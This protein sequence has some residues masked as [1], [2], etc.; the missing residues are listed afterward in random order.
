MSVP[1]EGD[2]RARTAETVIHCGAAPARWIAAL[3]MCLTLWLLPPSVDNRRRVDHAPPMLLALT[4]IDRWIAR[5]L[6]GETLKDIYPRG[7]RRL[8]EYGLLRGNCIR[9]TKHGF[10]MHVDRLDAIKWAIHYFGE[11][12][13]H[14]S[15]AYKALLSPGGVAI[16][17]GA[18][19]G[20][21]ALLA[22][23]LVQRHGRVLAFEPASKVY[24]QLLSNIALNGFTQ[25]EPHKCAVADFRGEA[26]LH[27]MGDNE[28]AQAS[29]FARD[30]ADLCETVPV[31]PFSDV[32]AM[33]HPSSVDLIKIDI[34]GAEGM[35][36]DQLADERNLNPR[37]AV[38]VEMTNADAT[39]ALERLLCAGFHARV[40][41]N[42][43]NTA[44]YRKPGRAPLAEFSGLTGFA[45]LVLS[46]D[47]RVFDAIN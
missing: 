38:F 16:D 29:M 22:A 2:F 21:H 4:D 34:E 6:P 44:F 47:E 18:N 41:R 37:C 27:M 32:L 46:R 25:I 20:Y 14:I 36:L 5:N 19:I 9:E 43:Y 17:L 23:Q 12:E 11:W 24:H 45:D 3:A 30:G 10:R 8:A 26:P 31:I 42:E 15:A 35:I 33:T 13:P 1:P 28:Q 40:I 7:M 39:P